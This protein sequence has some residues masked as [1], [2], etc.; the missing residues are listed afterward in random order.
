[1]GLLRELVA[2]LPQQRSVKANEVLR[3]ARRFVG[4]DE[5]QIE[6]I[7]RNLEE[8]LRNAQ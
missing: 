2:L 8:D 3:R 4:A 7:I 6:D 1:M 5:R